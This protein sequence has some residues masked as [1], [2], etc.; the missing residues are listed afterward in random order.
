MIAVHT[1]FRV[2][3]EI[4]AELD[5][6]RTEI[7][8]N[9]VEIEMVDHTGGL[10]D[11]RIGHAIVVAAFLRA[12]HRCLLLRPADEHHPL[13][14]GERGEV[15][16]HDVVLPLA[17]DEIDPRNALGHGE[18]LHRG[19]EPVGDLRQRRCRGDR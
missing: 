9:T 12:E 19:D 2:I 18:P 1:Q 15:L 10:H 7:A 11:P 8:V 14:R 5:E 13:L 17:L 3:R 4:G 6:E 16:M